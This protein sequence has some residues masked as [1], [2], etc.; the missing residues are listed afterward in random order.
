MHYGRHLFI[1]ELDTQ[2]TKSS[3]RH[4]LAIKLNDIKNFG[5]FHKKFPQMSSDVNYFLFFR[6]EHMKCTSQADTSQWN[7]N[8]FS[9]KLLLIIYLIL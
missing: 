8:H 5:R 9:K 7:Q 4:L 2:G 3:K 6:K 1:S